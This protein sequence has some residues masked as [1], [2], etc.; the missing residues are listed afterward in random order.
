[1]FESAN[2]G[3]LF[4]DEIAELT[5]DAQAKLLRVLQNGEIRPL[6]SQQLR[7]VDVRVISATNRNLQE[8]MASGRFREDL[9]FRLHGVEVSLPPL[10]QRR[11]EVP[12]LAVALL[13]RINQKFNRQRS[14]TKDALARLREH[15]WPGNVRE[16]ESVLRESVL[17]AKGEVLDTE[18]LMISPQVKPQDYFR[19]LPGPEPGFDLKA[20]L[21]EVR[22]HLIRMALSK[23]GGNQSQAAELLGITKQAVNDFLNASTEKLA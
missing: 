22:A 15:D 19:S 1:M 3:T 5:P 10:R 7:H 8:E 2:G 17:F 23:S 6:G 13:D 21:A 12:V 14:V 9:Y 18:D 11:A 4:L 20:F 16:L